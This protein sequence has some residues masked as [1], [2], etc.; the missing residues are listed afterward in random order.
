VVASDGVQR[1]AATVGEPCAS[2]LM[3]AQAA[4][5]APAPDA[6]RADA[7]SK[8]PA[9][10]EY[11]RDLTAEIEQTVE[12]LARRRKNNAVLIG[13]AG[14]PESAAAAQPR[15]AAAA[16]L[17]RSPSAGSSAWAASATSVSRSMGGS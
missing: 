2:Q 10:D 6:Q 3:A 12:M 1:R 11:G 16:R 5:G 4:G 15:R 9:L 14:A 13:E 17:M 7:Q 8:T